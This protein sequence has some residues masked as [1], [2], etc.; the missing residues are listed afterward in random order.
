MKK[1]LLSLLLAATMVFS[2]ATTVMADGEGTTPTQTP[3]YEQNGNKYKDVNSVEITKIYELTNTGT[4]SPAEEFSFSTL[5]AV[6]VE[7]AAETVTVNNMPIPKIGT[8]SFDKEAATTTGEEKKVIITLPDISENETVA[9]GER[10]TK[11]PSVGVYTYEFTENDQNTAG[12]AYYDKTMKLVVTVL[13]DGDNGKLRIAGVHCEGIDAATGTAKTDKFTN[14]YSAGSLAISKTVTGNLGDRSKYFEVTV[15]FTAP[16]GDTVREDINISGS[17][18]TSN[19]TVVKGVDNYAWDQTQTVT[20]KIKHGETITFSNIPYGVTYRVT[21]NDYTDAGY[22][23]AEY[24]GTDVE[25]DEWKLDSASETVSITNNKNSKVD[26]GISVDSLPYIVIL[27]AV[28][29]C[30]VAFVA[31]KRSALND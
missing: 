12:V 2:M 14:T 3:T 10:Y 21:E 27:A 16:A 5:E 17:S 9:D 6:S 20:L 31:R 4:T 22:D 15:E 8:V 7:N 18:H 29:V 30:L 28:V 19:Q 13:Q 1:K 11:Y 26:T 23:A 25:N 24:A